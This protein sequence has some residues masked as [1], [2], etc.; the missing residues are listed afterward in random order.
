MHRQM[1]KIRSEVIMYSNGST[2]HYPISESMNTVGSIQ[3]TLYD[4]KQSTRLA[5]KPK[6]SRFIRKIKSRN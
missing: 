1:K 3:A 5:I 2:D 4:L 6:D